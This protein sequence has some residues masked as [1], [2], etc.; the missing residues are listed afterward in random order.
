MFPDEQTA[1]AWNTLT[2]L[3]AFLQVSDGVLN[4]LENNSRSTT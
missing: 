4:A 2:E 3:K 1:M